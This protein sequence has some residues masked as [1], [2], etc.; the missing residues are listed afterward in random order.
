MADRKATATAATVALTPEDIADA[1]EVRAT[2]YADASVGEVVIVDGYGV[3]VAVRRGCLELRDG[4]GRERRVRTVTKAQAGREVRRVLVLGTGTVTTEAMRFCDD[5]HLPLIVARPGGAEPFMVGAPALDDHGGLRRAQALAAYT[6]LAMDVTRWLLDRRLADQ[7]RIAS[8]LLYREDVAALAKDR[9]SA[10]VDCESASEALLVESAA[11]VAYWSAWSDVEVRF[12]PKDRPRVPEHWFRFGGRRS[13]LSV[14]GPTATNRHAGDVVNG[15]A[16]FGYWL[17]QS[18]A[19]IALLSMGLDPSLGFFHVCDQN[20]PAA[21]L[22][23]MEAGRGVVEEAVLRLVAERVWRKASFVESRSGELRLAA[24]VAHELAGVLS[25]VLRESLG[26]VAEELGARLL[27]LVQGKARVSV[28][29]PLSRSR[30][31]RRGR[32]R[33]SELDF[34]PS[35][36]GCGRILPAVGRS[37]CDACLPEARRLGDLHEVGPARRRKRTRTKPY[38]SEAA[39]ARAESMRKRNAERRAWEEG[40]KGMQPPEPAEFEA[41][42]QGLTRFSVVEV[43]AAV[44]VSKSMGRQIR[45]GALVPHLR[46]WQALAE[47]AGV[48]VSWP[49]PSRPS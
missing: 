43:A 8:K 9:R 42:R 26:P 41:I 16:N 38:A 12:A 24:P 37:W 20:R 30:H 6:P 47:M 7:A 32:T 27:P 2:T 48:S 1:A 23:L 3:V 29:T 46:H 39:A 31:G 11:A 21:V 40:H 19:Q 33:R 28:P 10:L 15:L 44:G 34:A 36:R 49:A 18:E 25:P 4:V 35:C 17:C 22:D 14:E 13:P 5:K 45:S